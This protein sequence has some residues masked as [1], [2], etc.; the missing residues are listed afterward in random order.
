MPSPE[1]VGAFD[2]PT[3]FEDWVENHDFSGAELIE[4]SLASRD[5]VAPC[6]GPNRVHEWDRVAILERDYRDEIMVSLWACRH[7]PVHLVTNFTMAGET[8]PYV[9]LGDTPDPAW[10]LTMIRFDPRFCR[11][12]THPEDSSD[13]RC[14][15]CGLYY[16]E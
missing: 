2:E 14:G 15:E 6:Q 4:Y 13:N 16:T 12:W 10:G 3:S 11:H 8:V 9:L 1:S 5:D 7:C